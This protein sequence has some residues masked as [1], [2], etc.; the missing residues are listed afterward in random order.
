MISFHLI[1]NFRNALD[2]LYAEFFKIDTDRF[3][4][5]EKKRRIITTTGW[6]FTTLVLAIYTPNIGVVIE[7]LG[8]LASM[9]VFIFPSICLIA[10]VDRMHE[11]TSKIG[12]FIQTLEQ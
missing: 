9:N 5:G 4:K 7:L 2:G 6:F 1:Y 11:K 3:I 10:I 12:K 8:S